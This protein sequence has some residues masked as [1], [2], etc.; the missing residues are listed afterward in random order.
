MAPRKT[1][2]RELA[3]QTFNANNGLSQQA[4][5]TF[6]NDFEVS[7][8]YQQAMNDD[9]YELASKLIQQRFH[10]FSDDTPT[11]P[12]KQRENLWDEVLKRHK[13]HL[14]KVHSGYAKEIGLASSRGSRRLR[15][16]PT[17]EFLESL[18]LATV[19][20]RMEFQE[21]LQL[22]YD[23]YK[24]IIGDQQATSYIESSQADKEAFH[25]NAERLEARLKS[26]GLLQ[27][28]SDA[29]AYVLNPYGGSHQCT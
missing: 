16:A 1:I 7:P 6:L 28:L 14:Y 25:Q 9:N 12:K 2:I 22:L 29:C 27:R 24:F 26:I 15:Y 23:R 11:P 21:F 20:V 18:V 4:L 17:D 8:E 13:Q 10:H 3:S 5:K 19:P